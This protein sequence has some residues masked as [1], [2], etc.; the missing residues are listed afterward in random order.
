MCIAF[1]SPHK[2]DAKVECLLVVGMAADWRSWNGRMIQ[3][4]RRYMEFFQRVA[5]DVDLG[6]I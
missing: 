4:G 5:Y 1:I 2:M 3:N 6:Q